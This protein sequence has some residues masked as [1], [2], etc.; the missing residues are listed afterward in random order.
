M[1]EDYIAVG[2]RD[3]R[4]HAEIYTRSTVLVDAN[5]THCAGYAIGA[6]LIVGAGNFQ[7]PAPHELL[8]LSLFQQFTKQHSRMLLREH[9]LTG[10]KAQALPDTTIP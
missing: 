9:A 4:L 3:H 6:R 8:I 10:A 5:P 2:Q 1:Q 7:I